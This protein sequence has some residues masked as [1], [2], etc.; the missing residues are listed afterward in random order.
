M[1]SKKI[2]EMKDD[3][4]L[5]VKVNKTYYLMT[6]ASIF[7]VFKELYDESG[8]PEE[9]IKQIVSQ[10]YKNMNDKERLFYTLSLLIGEIEKQA[11]ETD[12]FI[13]KNVDIK[14]IKK[15]L[16]SKVKSNED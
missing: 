6:K 5:N 11:L 2:K 1:E 12:S 8:N 15:D 13:E 3:A 7:T 9:F 10:E 16:I 14:D 4:L